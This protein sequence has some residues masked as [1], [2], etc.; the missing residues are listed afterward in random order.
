MNKTIPVT[1]PYFDQE[2]EAE[3]IATLRSGW[4]VQGPKVEEFENKIAEYVG[5]K[6]AVATSSCT[7]ALH[8]A[9]LLLDIGPGDE[10]IV[11]SFTFIAT[12]NSIL[13]V[14]ATPVFA[15]VDKDTYNLDPEDV[16]R[17]ITK[18]T[19]VIMPVHQVGLAA[20]MQEIVQIAK[21]SNIFIVEDAACAL[22]SRIDGKHVGVFGEI[23]CFSFH[24]RKS[25]TTA[26]GG[27][28]VTNNEDLAKRARIL[29]AHGMSVSDRERHESKHF[30][31]ETY[32]VLGYNYRMSDIHA[33]IGLAQFRK[34]EFI[35]EKRATLASRYLKYLSEIPYVIPPSFP[36][37]YTH[38]FQSYVIRLSE[39]SPISREILMTRLLQNGISTRIG[40]KACHLEPLYRKEKT[41]LLNTE[42]LVKTI[43]TLPLYTTMTY[44]EQDRVINNIREIFVGKK[45]K[46][47]GKK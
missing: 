3:V 34:L 11:P 12:A 9:L 39:K 29:R 31:D 41:T 43:I 35:L 37:G 20:F 22:G 32:K 16:K 36:Q 38:T 2:E 45:G 24:P 33:A 26:E 10:V 25:I 14:G 46:Y 27:M 47:N 4:V 19:R 44:K 15:D 1:K 7:T 23:G 40:I 5:T 8:L 42:L 17:K 28:L 13:Y 18:H 6:Y 30:T 21:R